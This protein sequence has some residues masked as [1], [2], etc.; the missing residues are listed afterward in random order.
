MAERPRIILHAG[1]HKTG[2]TAIQELFGTH[3][4]PGASV[5]A[6]GMAG[7]DPPGGPRANLSDVVL[8]LFAEG[9]LLDKTHAARWPHLSRRALLRARD[10]TRDRLGARIESWLETGTGTAPLFLVSAEDISAPDFDHAAVARMAEFFGRFGAETHVHAYA[11]AP[12]SFMQSAFQQRVKQEKPGAVDLDAANLWP[13]Y[14]ARFEPLDDVFGPDRVHLRAFDPDA[15]EGGDV[16]ADFAGWLGLGPVTAPRG[17]AND[18]LSCEAVCVIFCRLAGLLARDYPAPDLA[19]RFRATPAR[20]LA[21]FGTQ[22]FAFSPAF[23]APALTAQ[24]ADLDWIEA[25]LGRALPDRRMATSG[26]APGSAA[27]MRAIAETCRD[28]L[29]RFLRQ[30]PPPPTGPRQALTRLGRRLHTGLRKGV[31]RGLGRRDEA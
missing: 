14:R 10:R 25:R 23:L 17:R 20:A 11:R 2:S 6:V 31:R 27:E 28:E 5:A 8:L 16:V 3:G 24:R 15:F 13:R 18:G 12:A 21:G 26:A 1:M 30:A 22:R 4:V 7:V 9:A 19:A 29:C